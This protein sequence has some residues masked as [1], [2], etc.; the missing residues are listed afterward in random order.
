MI[1][2]AHTHTHTHPLVADDVPPTTSSSRSMRP[3]ASRRN[4]CATHAGMWQNDDVVEC[5]LE[6]L[7]TTGASTRSILET[8]RLCRTWDR[9]V[10][11]CIIRPLM[12]RVTA[13]ATAISCVLTTRRIALRWIGSIE[14][15]YSQ[16]FCSVVIRVPSTD[17]T[18]CRTV[19]RSGRQCQNH[20]A[21]TDTGLCTCHHK[22]LCALS[23]HPPVLGSTKR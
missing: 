14:R 15:S 1:W 6:Q 2:Y 21:H 17:P 9:V 3:R 20:I 10:E 5:V 19:A 22:R 18:R 12:K 4:W 16:E 8:R 13:Y 23:R 11:R 7:E